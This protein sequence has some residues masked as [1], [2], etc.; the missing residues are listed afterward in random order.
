MVYGWFMGEIPASDAEI[1]VLKKGSCGT[2]KSTRRVQPIQFSQ[3]D[4]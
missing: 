1:A 4:F 3:P 2:K